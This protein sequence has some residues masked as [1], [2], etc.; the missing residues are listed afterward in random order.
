MESLTN[1]ITAHSSKVGKEIATL[2]LNEILINISREQD[3]EKC[4]KLMDDYLQLSENEYPEI[5]AHYEFLHARVFLHKIESR[6]KKRSDV[7]MHRINLISE[8]GSD[9]HKSNIKAFKDL[10]ERSNNLYPELVLV[11]ID[12]LGVE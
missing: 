3:F 1:K 7:N 6:R 8:K 9:Q 2:L 4:R 10:L 5:R 12:N 11:L